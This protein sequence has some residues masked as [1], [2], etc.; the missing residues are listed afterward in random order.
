MDANGFPS[1]VRL[2][3]LH[4]L[5]YEEGRKKTSSGTILGG[6]FL[7]K[8]GNGYLSPYS[9]KGGK[10]ELMVALEDA[11]QGRRMEDAYDDTTYNFIPYIMPVPGDSLC[12]WL[13]AGQNVVVDDVLMH[14]GDGT[15]TKGGATA[16]LYANAADS[17]AVTNTTAE[18]AFDKTYTIP[19]GSLK[20]GDTIRIRGYAIATATNS[21]DTL[22]I[23][24]KIGSTVLF[25]APAT[26]V[27]N[28][29]I[30]EFDALLTIRTVGATGTLVASGEYSIGVPGTATKRS[31]AVASTTIDT[32]ATQLISL[33]ATWSVANSGNSTVL[34]QLVVDKGEAAGAGGAG[35]F[36]KVL[37]A[38]DLSLES[39]PGKVKVRI[40]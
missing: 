32:T 29:D 21:T 35:G 17:A 27:A 13:A 24:L 25:T 33:T 39:S 19:A 11:L 6:Y 36:C 7:E 38:R 8:D 18:T 2:K 34:R 40:F 5:A 15:L 12:C 1:T 3:V 26:D 30:V 4:R 23:K 28:G 37:E 14:N 31:F 20:V 10:D 22:S 9:I 16:N